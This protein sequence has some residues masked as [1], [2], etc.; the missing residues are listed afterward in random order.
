[1]NLLFW[2]FAV[3]QIRPASFVWPLMTFH[4]HECASLHAG[5]FA[6]PWKKTDFEQLI[7]SSSIV[8]EGAWTA[9]STQLRGFCMSRIAADE[10][11]I[12][13]LVVERASLRQGLAAKLVAS[14]IA[15]L[16]IR[17]VKNL[18]LEVD[19]NNIA[20]ISLYQGLGFTEMGTRKGYYRGSQDKKSTSAIVMRLLI[21]GS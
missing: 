19:E 17:G 16:S 14:Q 7:A 6:H 4:A 5:F 9:G 1:M 11:E 15:R 10:A 20:A 18:F 2:P 21:A 12:L 13:T 8:A 3:W